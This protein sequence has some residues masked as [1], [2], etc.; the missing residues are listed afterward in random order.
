MIFDLDGTLL[1]TLEDLADSMNA[2]LAAKE[3]PLHPV[4]AYRYFVGNGV[5][6]LVRRSLPAGAVEDGLVMACIDLM[7]AEYGRRWAAKTTAYAGI[8]ALLDALTDRG[9]AMAVLSNKP[10][11][12]TRLAVSEILKPWRFSPVWGA[13]PDLPKKPDPT[14]AVSIAALLGVAPDCCLY[15]GDTDTDMETATRAGMFAV[16]VTWGFRPPA[17]LEAAGA[18]ALVTEPKDVISLLD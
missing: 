10:E 16:G 14:G 9:L 11:E 18:Q 12:F 15:L 4:D 3:Y 6:Q 13:R 17:E 2:V 8:P 1:D 5:E 7:E